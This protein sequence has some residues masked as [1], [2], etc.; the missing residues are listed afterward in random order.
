MGTRV[1]AVTVERGAG[2]G[3]NAPMPSKGF[4]EAEI[5]RKLAADHKL[6]DEGVAGFGGISFARVTS[7]ATRWAEMWPK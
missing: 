4:M 6:L 3:G 7:S 1:G 5:V 2:P